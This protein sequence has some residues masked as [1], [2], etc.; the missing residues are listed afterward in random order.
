MKFIDEPPPNTLPALA[1]GAAPLSA[2]E[3]LP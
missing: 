3:G 2:G 1:K